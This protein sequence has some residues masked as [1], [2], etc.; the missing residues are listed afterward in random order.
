MLRLTIGRENN[1]KLQR[2]SQVGIWRMCQE[3]DPDAIGWVPD[4][5]QWLGA[6]VEGHLLTVHCDCVS[7]RV[8]VT[9]INGNCL[10]AV[11]TDPQTTLSDLLA[12]LQVK[13]DDM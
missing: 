11:K 8:E 2:S 13:L 10:V 6:A 7:W 3:N 4:D 12:Q 5:K 1:A 9:D